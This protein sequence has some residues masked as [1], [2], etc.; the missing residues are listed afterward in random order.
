MVFIKDAKRE[1]LDQINNKVKH[2]YFKEANYGY[3]INVFYLIK[4]TIIF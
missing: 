1:F 4:L 3:E 2:N